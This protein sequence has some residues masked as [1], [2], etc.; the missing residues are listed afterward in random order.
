LDLFIR[1]FK[2]W[3][4]SFKTK[5]NSATEF[6][7]KLQFL[8][9]QTWTPIWLLDLKCHERKFQELRRD[10]QS[11]FYIRGQDAFSARLEKIYYNYNLMDTD[12][13]NYIQKRLISRVEKWGGPW[14]GFLQTLNLRTNQ[15]VEMMNRLL[16][17]FVDSHSS[18]EETINSVLEI[19]QLWK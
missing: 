3:I 13:W 19:S 17:R 11:L 8:E 5:I 6:L 12:L 10:F 4:Q 16:K 15:N 7:L 9:L 2:H 14:V 18:I 1:I